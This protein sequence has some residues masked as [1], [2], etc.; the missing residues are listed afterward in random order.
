MNRTKQSIAEAGRRRDNCGILPRRPFC[1]ELDENTA[2]KGQDSQHHRHRLPA[3]ERR[4]V[5]RETIR[6]AT[7][8]HQLLFRHLS[9][10]PSPPIDSR[11]PHRYCIDLRC[12]SFFPPTT[13]QPRARPSFFW[14]KR[15]WHKHALVQS[16]QRRAETTITT[17]AI[18][19]RSVSSYCLAS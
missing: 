3:N 8:S 4:N 2:F 18:S 13:P 11:L 15:F 17:S 5:R 12:R 7:R 1:Y 10:P 9:H 19:L 16:K 6:W 14:I